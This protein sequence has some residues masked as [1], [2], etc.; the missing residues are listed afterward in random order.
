[1][2]R[3]VIGADDCPELTFVRHGVARVA[4]HLVPVLYNDISQVIFITWKLPPGLGM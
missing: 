1:M 3:N 2:T 4:D